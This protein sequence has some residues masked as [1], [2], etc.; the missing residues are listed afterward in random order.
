M[1]LKLAKLVLPQHPGRFAW[2]HLLAVVS[3]AALFHWYP[4][5]ATY[6]ADFRNPFNLYLIKPALYITLV[7][8]LLFV[9]LAHY[10]LNNG[11]L[12]PTL[13][14]LYRL[15]FGFLL[16]FCLLAVCRLVGQHY[17]VGNYSVECAADGARCWPELERWFP[18]TVS[19]HLFT[20]LGSLLVVAE[21]ATVFA[22]WTRIRASIAAT[23]ESACCAVDA[24]DDS[25]L[26]SRRLFLKHA[27]LVRALYVFLAAWTLLLQLGLLAS[28]AYFRQPYEKVAGAL[29]ALFHWQLTYRCVCCNEHI[30]AEVQKFEH[31]NVKRYRTVDFDSA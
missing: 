24:L 19:G 21:E 28:V 14:P 8:S 31:K 3:L 30:A 26:I 13:L 25:K 16:Y 22:Q 11:S 5:P 17:A 23:E 7:S 15:L 1:H 29:L 12:R 2:L 18:I 9:F 6:L 27:P 4:P 10:P 20:T